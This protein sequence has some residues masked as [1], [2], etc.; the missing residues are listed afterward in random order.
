MPLIKCYI[1]FECCGLHG[2][3]VLL[4]YALDDGPI[5]LYEVWKEPVWKTLELIE[6]FMTYCLVGFNLAF[7]MFHICKLY[8]IWKLLPSD[9]IPETDIELVARME[10]L[11]R[12][13]PCVKPASALDLMLHSRKGPYQMLMARNDVR[14]R[15][16]P[17]ILAGALAQE[18]EKRVELEGILFAKRKDQQAPRWQVHDRTNHDNEVDPDFKDVVLKFH[19]AGGLKFLAEYV[20]GYKPDF[21]FEDIECGIRPVEK[22]YIPFAL[23]LSD[24]LDDWQVWDKQ[25][26]LLGKVWPGV[27]QL[28]IDHWHSSKE[29][30][31]YARDDVKYTRRLDDHFDYPEPGDD[32]SILSCMV[33]SVRWHGFVVDIE[34][35]K[36]LLAK[37]RA[38]LKDSPVNINKPPQVRRYIKDCMDPTEALLI[39]K[40]T[41]KANIEQIRDEMVVTEPGEVC[42]KC[43]GTAR[44]NDGPCL[45][46]RGKGILELGPMAVSERASEILSIKSAAKEAELHTKLVEA[47][48]FHASFNVIGTLS[49]RMSGGSDQVERRSGGG[50]GG[51][52]NAQGIKRSKEVREMFP[53]AWNG[54]VLCGGDFDSFEVVLADTVFK[55]PNLRNELLA[56]KKIHALMGE[57]LYPGRSYEEICDSKDDPLLDMYSRGKQA[58]FGLLYGGDHNT[59]HNKLSVSLAIAEEVFRNFQKRFPKIKQKRDEVFDR[60]SALRQPGGIGTAVIWKDPADFSETFLGFRRFFT[61]ENKIVKALFDLA[62]KPPRHWSKVKLEVIRSDRVQSAAGAVASALYGAAFQLQASNTRAANNHLIQSPGG[63]ITKA[64]QRSIWDVQP[65]GI[66]EWFVAPMNIHDEVMVAT[67]P[68]V[69]DQ[70]AQAVIDTVE[71]YRDRVPLIRMDWMA[72]GMKNW[73]DKDSK[74]I[75]KII[76]GPEDLTDELAT[77]LD[78]KTMEGG[79]FADWDSGMEDFSSDELDIL[80][81]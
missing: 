79:G 31:Q 36:V 76:I 2:M 6:E 24:P 44:W 49:S 26:K 5:Q 20:L 67:K 80:F 68:D 3:P 75:P 45:R 59:I 51:G 74:D 12:D 42:I 13:G 60:F 4:Q 21:H 15:K 56:G 19:P 48:R 27:I 62:R 34:K 57:E 52:L 50:L 77:A 64:V 38:V 30:R 8:T 54:M 72:T 29:A 1:D 32:D 25:G 16:I 33:A 73:G 43:L 9:L 18:L 55:D 11:G 53:L 37:A 65:A 17:T 46:C 23:G 81:Q 78:D 35:A 28:H 47:G 71:S 70:V 22:G 39:D 66:N 63:Q 14:I 61:L 58:V 40:S 10:P 69:T 41:M 7:D